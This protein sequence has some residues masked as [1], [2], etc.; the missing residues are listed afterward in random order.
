MTSRRD[1]FFPLRL[2]LSLSPS[3]FFETVEAIFVEQ[4]QGGEDTYPRFEPRVT[5]PIFVAFATRVLRG[6]AWNFSD[7]RQ[8][9][10]ATLCS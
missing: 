1:S 3:S 7:S 8:A 9:E 4:K 5:R 10:S 2:S 6:G